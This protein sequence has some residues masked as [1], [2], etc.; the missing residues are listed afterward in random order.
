MPTLNG[1]VPANGPTLFCDELKNLLNRQSM[2][3][4]SNTP[5]SILAQYLE[6]CL[7]VFDTA[8]QQRETWHGRD[9]RPS[10]TR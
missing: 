8:V 6:G 3:N 9:S 10:H 2:E 1:T 5:D 4:G 7:K